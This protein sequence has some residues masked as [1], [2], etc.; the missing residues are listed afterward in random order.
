MT[1][2]ER[3][4]VVKK[5]QAAVGI[6]ERRVIRFTGFP[7][8]TMRYPSIR[9]PQ[10]ALRIRIRELAHLRKRWGYRMIHSPPQGRLASESKTRPA[11]L[12]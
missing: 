2:R 6:S 5:I 4:H 1:A 10:E 11:S 12:P 8:S 3:R 9:E 7:R